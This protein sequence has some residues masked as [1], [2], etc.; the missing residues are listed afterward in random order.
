MFY[1]QHRIGAQSN[2]L[3][4]AHYA[5]TTNPVGRLSKDAVYW[6]LRS[7]ID[8]YPELSLIGVPQVAETG[9]KTLLFLAA[10]HEI[11]METCV[12]F[13]DDH[14]PASGPEV[15]E[16]LHNEWLWTD[17]TFNP[18]SP[19]WKIVV[20]GRQEVVFVFHHI[21]CDGRFGHFFHRQF[22]D[23]LNSFDQNQQPLGYIVKVDPERTRLSKETEQFWTSSLSALRMAHIFIMFL[24][25]RFFFGNR[26]F[27]TDLPNAKPYVKSF[28]VDA[29]P[30]QRTKTRI[31]SVRIPAARMRKIIGACREQKASF[32]PLLLAMFTC[33]LAIDYYPE[34]KIGMSNCAL[35]V[36]SLYPENT[37]SS[38]KLFQCAAAVGN[39]TWLNK[40]RRVFGL[41]RADGPL[42]PGK[43]HVDVQGAWDLVREYRE[44]I[45]KP[46]Q[47]DQPQAVMVFKAS[48]GIADDL[49]GLMKST[50]SALGLHLNNCF[51]VS[52][53]GSF[54]TSGE[55]EKPWKIDGMSF[56]ASTVN[57]SISYGISINVAGVEG[58]VTVI[59]VSYEDGIIAE[60]MVYG[61]LKGTLERIEAIL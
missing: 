50:L 48:N 3:L 44:S 47:G 7:V 30:H 12:E 32:T 31:A 8:A 27:F 23:G 60:D 43:T 22:L 2:V 17:A 19:W 1:I 26:L 42:K 57:G 4:S 10:L 49:E 29:E 18:R 14:E 20:L 35:D 38:G 28:S 21:V 39:M 52:N 58:G 41:R 16:K 55:R 61:I 24:L 36:R 59:N 6:A 37:D 5:P 11:D 33:T 34:A 46:F 54:S 15:L 45:R 40:Y 25:L 13:F 9:K 53:I 56:S 51:Q